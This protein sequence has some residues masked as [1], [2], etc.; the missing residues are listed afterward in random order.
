MGM[1][2]FFKMFI[3]HFFHFFHFKQKIK[4]FQHFSK[5]SWQGSVTLPSHLKRITDPLRGP[6][7]WQVAAGRRVTSPEGPLLWCNAVCNTVCQRHI[8]TCALGSQCQ[9]HRWAISIET[10]QVRKC[11]SQTT[12]KNGPLML[13]Y[14]LELLVY[15][16]NYIVPLPLLSCYLYL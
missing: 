8:Y 6:H 9:I 16:F 5:F 12:F 2:H 14:I 3:F 13:T 7:I 4:H 10:M 15:F 1:L 11:S